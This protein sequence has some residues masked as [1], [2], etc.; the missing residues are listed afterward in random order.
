MARLRRGALG[1]MES[2]GTREGIPELRGLT[3]LLA[4]EQE[5]WFYWVPVLMGAGIGLYFWLPFEPHI[6]SAIALPPIALALWLLAPRHVLLGLV[7]GALLAA[8]VGFALAKLRVE[9]VRAPV[10]TKPMTA[11]V[12]GWLEVVEPTPGSGRKLTLR[13][14]SLG[15]LA[16]EARPVRITF[17]VRSSEPD[18]KAGDAIKARATLMPP[19]GPALPGGFDFAR[20]VWFERIGAVGYARSAPGP[21]PQSGEAPWDLRMW[22]AIERLRRQIGA[23]VT[24]A[25]PGESGAIANALIA[26]E[27]GGISEATNDAYR[28]SGLIHVLSISGLHM[29]IM[30]GSVF[31]IVR[32]GLAAIPALALRYPIKKWA[33]AAAMLGAFGYLLISGMAFPTVRSAIMIAIMLFAV[34]LE[35][36]ALALRNVVL[37]AIVILVLFPESLLD[38]GFQMSFAAVAALLTAYEGIRGR[39]GFFERPSARVLMFFGGIV[40]STLVASVAV[41]PLGAYHFHRSQQYAVLANLIAVPV[42]NLIV[43]PAALATL[44]ALPFGL[45]AVPLWVM[46]MG[47][48]MM[49]WTAARVASMPGA[50]FPVPAMPLAAFLCMVAGGLWLM[51]WKTR[52]R[53]LG[54]VMIA[55]GIALAPMVRLPDLLIG[56]DAKLVAVRNDEGQLVALGSSTAYE[57]ERWLENDGDGR[58]PREVVKAR[59]FFCD[60]AGCTTRVKGLRVAVAR[61]PAAFSDDCRSARVLVASLVKPKS[62]TA[63]EAVIDFFS[64]RDQGVHAIYVEEDQRLRVETVADKRGAR[65][66]SPAPRRRSRTQ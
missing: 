48:D 18:L 24:A 65:P 31:F 9:W 1:L 35:R 63:P 34:L 38:A 12:A 16:P 49:S 56:R 10:V 60:G 13:V 30:A 20:K 43:M 4:A 6:L 55:G 22:S 7:T 32:L 36:P 3:G 64:A 51:L 17:T 44:L 61:H 25:L 2:E 66:W 21:E 50:V 62:C 40:L 37:A 27:R 39:E 5:R 26:G 47:I 52:W 33:A 53:F 15:D 42:C 58:S 23:R 45:E 54:V 29:A 46:G 41:A 57:L 59:G 14:T 28:D 19:P 11:E 8:S